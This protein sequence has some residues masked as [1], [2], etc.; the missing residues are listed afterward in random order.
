MAEKP[1]QRRLAAIL[2]ADVVGY[3][4]MMEQDEAGTLAVLKSRLRDVLEPIIVGHQGRVFKL[5]GDGVFVEFGSAVNA[6]QCAVEL[7]KG[8][9]AVNSEQPDQSAI[10]MRVGINLGDVMVEGSDLFGDG[11]NIAARLEGL[12][13]PGGI[14]ISGTAYD[15]VRNKVKVR[16]EDLGA[17]TVKNIAE[18]VRVYRVQISTAMA[19]T[20]P[21]LALPDKPSIAV[22]PFQNMSGD[23]EQEYFA[24]GMV[25]DITTALSRFRQLFVIARNS[26]F[27]YKGRAVDVKHVGREL[28][29]RY[30]LEGSVRKAGNRVR[31]TGQLIDAATGTHLWADRFDGAIEDIFELQDQVTE[32]VV[33]AIA[34]KVE[35]AEIE[36]AKHKPTESL[37]AYDNYLRGMA[38]YHLWTREGNSEALLCFQRA[39]D[40][41]FDFASA[42]GMAARTY[43]QRKSGGWFIDQAPEIAEISRL[44][45]RAVALGK[46]DAVA[47]TMAGL[48]LAYGVGDLD[49]ADAFIDQALVLNPNFASAWMFSGYVK[50]WR[51]EPEA[52]IERLTHAMRLSPHDPQFF[53]AQTMISCAH[54]T[55]GHYT[56]A[57]SWA[58]K[59]VRADPR[60][61]FAH[62]AI[63]ASL[64]LAGRLEEAEEAVARLR[65]RQPQLRISDLMD[66]LGSLRRPEDRARWVDGLRK[67]G[68]PE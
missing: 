44:A 21:V 28:G 13:E 53:H 66:Y 17:Q 51:G 30:V 1:A 52:A 22:L 47:L 14:L 37:D 54:F 20:R 16:F 55:L 41:D 6:V 12:A 46:D 2:A 36:R 50:T 15:H 43:A 4:R 49:D 68:V 26:S 32:S 60:P 7:Q 8:M 67:A 56:E 63:A 27:T 5:T 40:L 59:A 24:D 35:K 29:V 25:E 45:R 65:Q 58:E 11:I 48:A 57:L 33:G 38:A 23:P 64:A 62:G 9:A 42:Y 31:I 34:P 19:S 39:I 61:I 3:S 18:P 10:V